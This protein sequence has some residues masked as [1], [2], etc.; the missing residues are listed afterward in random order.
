MNPSHPLTTKTKNLK[1]D[2]G[3]NVR[4][5]NNML[6]PSFYKIKYVIWEQ[7]NTH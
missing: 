2:A 5:K 6:F 7:K 1:I 4:Y 3:K